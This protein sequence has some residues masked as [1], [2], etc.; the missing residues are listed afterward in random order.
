MKNL[1]RGKPFYQ[2]TGHATA[3]FEQEGVLFDDEGKEV[4]EVEDLGQGVSGPIY[5]PEEAEEA[6]KLRDLLG[7]KTAELDELTA[8]LEAVK[9]GAD[10]KEIELTQLRQSLKD[11]DVKYEEEVSR[12]D[13]LQAKNIQLE[14]KVAELEAKIADAAFPAPPADK[15]K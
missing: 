11:A 15:K 7:Q 5:T 4:I 12:I 14:A 8:E 1:D 10:K 13:G 9:D 3:V 2:V 6:G